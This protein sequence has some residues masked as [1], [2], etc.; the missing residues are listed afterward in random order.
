MNFG[1]IQDVL[2]DTNQDA[3]DGKGDRPGTFRGCSRGNSASCIGKSPKTSSCAWR[4]R[5]NLSQP[6]STSSLS[7]PHSFTLY[8]PLIDPF[9]SLLDDERHVTQEKHPFCI[10]KTS[11]CVIRTSPKAS[12][13]SSARSMLLR[14]ILTVSVTG[15]ASPSQTPLKNHKKHINFVDD[16]ILARDPVVVQVLVLVLEEQ[17]PELNDRF[18]YRIR[19]KTYQKAYKTPPNG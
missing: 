6:I 7:L 5:S 4:T 11:T 8:V 13:C 17:L 3:F 18:P 16:H 19:P 10:S 2:A 1:L 14:Q 9:L 12:L 15:M